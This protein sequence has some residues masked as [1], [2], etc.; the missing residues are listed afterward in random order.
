MKNNY[1]LYTVGFFP[2]YVTPGKVEIDLDLKAGPGV[3]LP[4]ILSDK[5]NA[6]TFT[7]EEG[8]VYYA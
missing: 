3:V 8:N 6:I 4:A 7:G 5:E 2:I 1:P